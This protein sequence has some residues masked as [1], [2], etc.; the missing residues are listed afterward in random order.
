VTSGKPDDCGAHC[1]LQSQTKHTDRVGTMY[2]WVW[3][4]GI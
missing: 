2:C 1:V 3:L 4:S